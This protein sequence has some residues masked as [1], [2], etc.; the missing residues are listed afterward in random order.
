VFPERREKLP[1][2][3]HH[4]LF[5]N[6]FPQNMSHGGGRGPDCDN[7]QA[8]QYINEVQLHELPELSPENLPKLLCRLFIE[9]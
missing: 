3:R 5:N 9:R 1:E 2:H 7:R 6:E 4:R 8:Q